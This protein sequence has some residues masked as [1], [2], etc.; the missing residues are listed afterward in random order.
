MIRTLAVGLVLSFTACDTT[1]PNPIRLTGDREVG[2]LPFDP[3]I[4]GR[5]GGFSTKLGARSAWTFGDTILASPG[6]DGTSWRSSTFGLTSDLDASDNIDGIAAPLDAA[7]APGELL[8]FTT[9]EAAYNDA[10]RA[11]TDGSC[12]AGSDCGARFALWPGPIVARGDAALIFYGKIDARPGDFNFNGI[13]TGIA[14]WDGV[15]PPV[16]AV[17]DPNAAEPHTLF[18]PDPFETVASAL[19][20]NDLVYVYFCKQSFGVHFCRL[21]RAPFDSATQPAAWT[22]FAGSDGWQGDFGKAHVVVQAAPSFSVHFNAHYQKYLAVYSTP[23]D[24]TLEMRVADAPEGPWSVSRV[25]HDCE[26]PA[27][28]GAWDYAGVGH[29][30]YARED[31]RTEY[32]TYYRPGDWSGEMRLVEVTFR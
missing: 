2:N 21:G 29:A 5:D 25:V 7:G 14:T 11:G 22:Y 24:N 19:L 28:N 9:E 15:N 17:I 31:G 18:A 8:P 27:V 6:V 20:V 4:K 16:R 3:I 1:V 26:A 13:G 10:H 23:L 30:E 12:P 32:M